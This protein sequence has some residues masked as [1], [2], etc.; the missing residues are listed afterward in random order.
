MPPL[1]ATNPGAAPPHP[2]AHTKPWEAY[3]KNALRAVQIRMDYRKKD[4]KKLSTSHHPLDTGFAT[5]Y[6]AL[7]GSTVERVIIVLDNLAGE[8]GR[9]LAEGLKGNTVLQQLDLRENPVGGGVARVASDAG[10]RWGRGKGSRLLVKR[11]RQ[12]SEENLVSYPHGIFA[13]PPNVKT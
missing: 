4:E 8:G 1:A 12:R 6:N 11:E 13:P 10:V 2:G 5:T 3:I 7:Q 9:A